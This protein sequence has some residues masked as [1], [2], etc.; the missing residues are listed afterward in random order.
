MCLVTLAG[1]PGCGG[2]GGGSS[3][4]P[5][6]Y[7]LEGT[8]AGLH[9]GAVILAN[10][11]G[12]LLTVSTDGG[13]SF[14]ATVA[15]GQQYNVTVATQPSDTTCAV[16][17]GVGTVGNANVN[18]VLV[19]C[20]LNH[21]YTLGGTVSG[22]LQGAL[23]LHNGSDA[24]SIGKNGAFTFA[25][26]LSPGDTYD[27]TV[28]QQ[29]GDTTCVVAAGA[30][31]V[32]DVD[33][34][35][36]AV[37]CT[38]AYIYSVGG[39]VSGLAAGESLTLENSGADP[40]TLNA[41]GAFTFAQK[42]TWLGTYNVTVTS[43]PA[44]QTCTVSYE[45]GGPVSADVDNVM[46]ECVTE[47]VLW[48]FGVTYDASSPWG[49]LIQGPDGALYGTTNGGGQY[50]QGT[51]YRITLDGHE[52][53]LWSFGSGS[54][55][56]NPYGALVLGSDGNFYGTT[57]AGG[58]HSGG[59]VYQLTPAGV[60]TVLWNFG[61]VAGDGA[62]PRAGLT[63]AS[64]GNFYGTTEQGGGTGW[65][66]VFKIT[67]AGQESVLWSFT[68]DPG[69]AQAPWAP[70]IQ[71]SDGNFYG[72]TALGGAAGWGTAFKVTPSGAETVLWS[73][74]P[75]SN[76]PG[77]GYNPVAP[78]LEGADGYLY[79]TTHDGGSV[80]GAGTV[81]RLDKQGQ[82]IASAD[83]IF[84]TFGMS[85]AHDGSNPQ[86]G[87]IIGKDGNFY[88]TTSSGGPFLGGT[89][90]KITP[91]GVESTLWTFGAGTDGNNSQ[92]PLLQLGD[93][94]LIGVTVSGGTHGRG[95]VFRIAP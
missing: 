65:G 73:F 74:V 34:T 66:S 3:S 61:T 25:L 17:S 29:P 58:T 15:S 68:D 22:L 72:T 77:N 13:F 20:T 91:A 9:S 43:Q 19:T 45:T 56:T 27:V 55:G 39:T 64:D 16:H 30:G 23:L 10:N 75:S 95:T 94:S 54:D 93:G 87:L 89:V 18:S 63:L 78:L 51:V 52:T 1:L 79:G 38:P 49:G 21:P 35:S 90:Y 86:A 83:S 28:A 69:D 11:G 33:I 42:L 36:V 5:P 82:G 4:S 50:L 92:A 12:D 53:V 14:G 7:Y 24:L 8:V 76:S 80:T 70:L 48:N 40:L 88:G 71:A 41:S 6:Q 26:P 47:T 81:V 60:E 67:P 37:S 57:Y 84:W 62:N 46:V 44:G 32:T 59:I 85:G 2:G 31:T